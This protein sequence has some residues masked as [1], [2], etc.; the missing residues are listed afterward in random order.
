MEQNMARPWKPRREKNQKSVQPWTVML[1]EAGVRQRLEQESSDMVK[2]LDHFQTVIAP[3]T[4]CTGWTV[5]N[6]WLDL[7]YK[8]IGD[9]WPEGLSY[10]DRSRI[11]HLVFRLDQQPA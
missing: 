6:D 9:H 1:A 5:F 8:R 4:D 7:C 11:R 3:Y 2:I 10:I